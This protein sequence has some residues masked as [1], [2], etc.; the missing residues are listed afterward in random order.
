[1]C[2]ATKVETD[3]AVA[4]KGGMTRLYEVF[5]LLPVTVRRLQTVGVFR[6]NGDGARTPRR[7]FSLGDMLNEHGIAEGSVYGLM[8]TKALMDLY[9]RGAIPVLTLKK[10][11][12][13]S[14]S[15]G[16]RRVS[17]R[18]STEQVHGGLNPTVGSNAEL[19]RGRDFFKFCLE[20]LR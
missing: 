12:S 6:C 4:P 1:M 15:D 14:L 20:L 11:H 5:Q 17:V 18:K 7:D 9:V 10:P 13:R 2:F 3:A 19:L 16:T 8:K